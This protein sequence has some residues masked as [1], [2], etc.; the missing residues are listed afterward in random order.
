MQDRQPSTR[1]IVGSWVVGDKSGFMC[2]SSARSSLQFDLL[3]K[4]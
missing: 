3:N 1:V 4:F 2:K